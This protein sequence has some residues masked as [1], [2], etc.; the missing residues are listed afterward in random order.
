MF[1][2]LW[3]M[4]DDDGLVRVMLEIM[5]VAASGEVSEGCEWV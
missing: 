5:R 2:M 4:N 1:E 3:D